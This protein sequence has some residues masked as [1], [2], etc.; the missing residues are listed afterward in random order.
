MNL[1]RPPAQTANPDDVSSY[2]ALIH[3]ALFT[4]SDYVFRT[5]QCFNLTRDKDLRL[6]QISAS[7]P[8]IVFWSVGRCAFALT[9]ATA[10]F[11]ETLEELRHTA[12]LS[13]STAEI[14]H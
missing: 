2:L 9:L 7:Y 1:S 3:A 6:A 4:H 14:T 13:T 12:Q 11:D 8:Y 10:V 5:E